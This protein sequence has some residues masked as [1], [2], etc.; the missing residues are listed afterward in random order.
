MIVDAT[1]MLRLYMEAEGGRKRP[2]IVEEHEYGGV[3]QFGPAYESGCDCRFIL[4][5]EVSLSLGVEH[6]GEIAFLDLSYAKT[7][8]REGDKIYLW[9]GRVI[10][11]GILLKYNKIPLPH[12]T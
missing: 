12:C 2:I 1:I 6:E 8:I 4:N 10:G 3:I 9:E 5:E 11:Q 7:V